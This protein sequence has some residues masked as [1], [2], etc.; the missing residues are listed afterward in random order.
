MDE[1]S[2]VSMYVD[3][4]STLRQ[5]ANRFNTDHHRIKRILVKNGVQITTK[6]RKRLPFTDE[7][8]SK[9]SASMKG[10]PGNWKDKK[11]PLTSL[12]KNMKAHLKYDVELEFLMKFDIDRLKMLNR[13]IKKDRMNFDTET[14]VQYIEKFHD[15]D[16][17]R[18]VYDIWVNSEQDKWALPTLDH[19]TPLARNGSN[20][21]SNLQVLTWFENRAK[22]D[23]TQ[24]E[25]DKFKMKTNS[26]SKYFRKI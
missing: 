24:D 6:G 21:L 9:I 8:K 5:I 17:F 19:I 18:N 15:D 4:K 2:I 7:H 11:M 22:C 26:S 10:K 16:Q 23:M 14:Y 1:Q 25:W 13:M 3:D 20:D 12:F